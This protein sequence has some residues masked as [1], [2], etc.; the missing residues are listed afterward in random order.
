MYNISIKNEPALL[1]Q[2]KTKNRIIKREDIVPKKFI[3]N[4]N[5]TEGE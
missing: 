2:F 1:I 5:Y 4:Q 3:E